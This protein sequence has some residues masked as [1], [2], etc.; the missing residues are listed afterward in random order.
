MSNAGKHY[1]AS[2]DHSTQAAR[3]KLE[4]RGEHPPLNCLCAWGSPQLYNMLFW[5][6]VNSPQVGQ[7]FSF[8]NGLRQHGASNNISFVN[9]LI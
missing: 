3:G 4:Q 9:G 2:L 6:N 1:E 8:V 5:Y 7:H